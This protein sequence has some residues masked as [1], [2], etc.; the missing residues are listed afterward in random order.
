MKKLVNSTLAFAMTVAVANAAAPDKNEIIVRENAVWRAVQQKKVE[1]F[2]QLV[3]ANI[4]AVYADG[5]MAMPDELKAIP[6]SA[7]KSVS[8]S[9]FKVAFPDEKTAMVAYVA[10]VVTSGKGKET[11][12]TYNAGSVWQLSKGQWRAIFHGEA[13]QVPA[14]SAPPASTPAG[15]HQPQSPD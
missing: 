6:K 3:S 10:K 9:D 13:K 14:L 2:K 5:I 12:T 11:T 1:Q 8:L 15:S 7:M 4:R